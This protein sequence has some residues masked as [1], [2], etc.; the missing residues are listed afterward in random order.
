VTLL[1]VAATDPSCYSSSV[2]HWVCPSYFHDKA[3]E[4]VN[5][6]T[7]HVTITVMAV[8]VGL[9]LAVPLAVLARR[10]PRL[11]GLILGVS[12]GIYTVPSLA[13]FPLLTPLTGI[14]ATT[15]I[16]G[17]ALYSLTILVRNTLAGLRSVPEEVRESAVGNGYGQTRLL[18]QVELPLALPVVMAGLRVATVS[19][20]ALTTVGSIVASGG[21]GNL[22]AHGVKNTFKAEIFAASVL[23]VVLALALDLLLMLVQRLLTPWARVRA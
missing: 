16:I 11:E 22:L 12:T 23:C 4:L 19:T 10:Y 5:A 21:L 18:L 15:V 2:N 13:L 20:V 17:L 1:T 8:L 6:T 3:D 7:E 9:V 14:S